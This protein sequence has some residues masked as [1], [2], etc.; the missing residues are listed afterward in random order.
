MSDEA[1][2][3]RTRLPIDVLDR[4]DRA[5][6]RFEAAWARR[7]AP[8]RGRPRRG[9]R[10]YRRALLRDLLAAEIAARR[11]LGEGPEPREYRDRFAGDDSAIDSAFGERTGP[12]SASPTRTRPS[13]APRPIPPSASAARRS[14]RGRARRSARTSS[15]SRSARA[16][17][18]TVF[19]AEQEQ[20]VR[21][22]VALKVIKPGMD[23][24]QVIAR[25]E[26][27]RQALAMMDHPNIARSSTPAPPR[28]AARSS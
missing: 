22:K 10:P 4:I 20:P 21:R 5:C 16:G 17:M 7:A 2:P 9:R 15:S 26:A 1:I 24:G 19:M 14:P 23:T 6:D 27:E 25:F 13:T 18:G 12:Q 11:R 8:H 3:D 28:P